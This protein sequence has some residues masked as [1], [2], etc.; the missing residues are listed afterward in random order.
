MAL[1]YTLSP[2]TP[3]FSSR[4]NS[5]SRKLP[6]PFHKLPLGTT[7]TPRVIFSCSARDPILPTSEQ[8]ILESVA[9]FY[10]AEKQ[11]PGVRTYEND[12]AR[13]TAVGAVGFQQA[14]T[15][16]AA[17]G[18]E[19]A[20]EHIES[21]MSNMV[22]HT[23]FP[24]PSDERSTI[25]TRLFLPAIKVREKA[26]KMKSSTTKDLLSSTTSKNILAMTF[27]Q[28]TLQ[29]LWNFE[30]ILFR[31]GTERKMDDLENLR[32]V[33][34]SFI[35]KS[36]DEQLISVLAEVI[37]LSAL[38]STQSCFSAKS[39]RRQSNKL[40]PWWHSPKRIMSKDS[41]VI[42]YNLLEHEVVANSATLLERFRLE[43]GK[44]KPKEAKWKSNWLASSAYLKLEWIGGP[45]FAAWVSECVPSYGL[46]I[47]TDN[48]SN[49]KLEGWQ[50]LDTNIH[51][52]VLTHSQMVGLADI[53]DMFYEDVYT[54][55]SKQL[56][57]G[58]VAKAVNFSSRKGSFSLLKWLSIV[59]A[60]GIFLVAAKVLQLR[61]LPYLP[62]RKN[63]QCQEIHSLHSYDTNYIQ[64]CF[65]ESSKLE[66]HCVSIIKRIKVAL[67][68]PGEIRTTSGCCAW[69][70]EI[71][72]FLRSTMENGSNV[73]D[74]SSSSTHLENVEEINASAQEIANYQVVLSMDGKIVGFQPTSR[75]AVNNWA[76]NPLTK[77]LYGGKDMSPG[78]LERGL[79]IRH[80]G[81]VVVLELLMSV[82]SK[83]HLGDFALVRPLNIAQHSE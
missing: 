69:I 41:S 58:A 7:R 12:L 21:G 68:W 50:E 23:V 40:F 67:G 1:A 80:P 3:L 56:S 32:E 36:S 43:I 59:L 5:L 52:V 16:A 8:A 20:D 62:N 24:G 53:L 45:E 13:L 18:G 15:A 65:M 76:S 63:P 14:L 39:L 48:F 61:F 72:K 78:F 75:V 51:W 70:G 33:P 42:L 66:A 6:L 38:E 11:L 34:A 10:G 60:T 26:K 82:N 27:R 83:S 73:S 55:P 4:T 77:E 2:A 29:Q 46:Q 22:V 35:L 37:C 79:N 54:L 64:N 17:D 57:S 47:N 71:P 9:E 25:S 81:Q 28:V 31:P 19:A 74:V 30:L 49:V 44:Y